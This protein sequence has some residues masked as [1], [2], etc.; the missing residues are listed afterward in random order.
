MKT[1]IHLREFKTWYL[2]N[3]AALL[4]Q[5]EEELGQPG[6]EATFTSEQWGDNF[7]SWLDQKAEE[8]NELLDDDDE[9]EEEV[10]EFLEEEG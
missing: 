9:G 6:Q 2:A 5:F 10:V 1:E 3:L 7:D 4:N 8:A